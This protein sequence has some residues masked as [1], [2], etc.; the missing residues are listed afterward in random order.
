MA[1]QVG[2]TRL[3]PLRP[4]ASTSREGADM[5]EDSDLPR[6]R[7]RRRTPTPS[8]W[9]LVAAA[10]TQRLLWFCVF[11]FMQTHPYENKNDLHAVALDEAIAAAI[12]WVAVAPLTYQQYARPRIMLALLRYRRWEWRH[13]E[14]RAEQAELLQRAEPP[15]ASS[16]EVM[17][18]AERLRQHD[19]LREAID[20]LPFDHAHLL[21]EVYFKGRWIKEVA[22]EMGMSNSAANRLHRDA[23]ARLRAELTRRGVGSDR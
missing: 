21:R 2:L 11:R 4:M 13:A 9:A 8:E 10:A 19:I 15:P 14:I 7:Q 16:W 22:P 5:V 23:L 18:A 12:D 1:D 3:A 6:G 20:A 17:G